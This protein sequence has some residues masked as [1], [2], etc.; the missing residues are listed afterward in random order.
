MKTSI[1][2]RS[3]HVLHSGCMFILYMRTRFFDSTSV[4]SLLSTTLAYADSVCR[5]F[6]GRVLVLNTPAMLGSLRT[7]TRTEVGGRL[8]WYIQ[9]ECVHRRAAEGESIQRWSSACSE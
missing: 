8:T 1:R 5:F 9:G 6:I 7:S 4:E 3:E 2:P